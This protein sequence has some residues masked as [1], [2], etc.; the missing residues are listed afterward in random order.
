LSPSNKKQH[1]RDKDTIMMHSGD[2]CS[3]IST[4]INDIEPQDS[5][6][7]AKYS[8]Q[9]Q[10]GG[11]GDCCKKEEDDGYDGSSIDFLKSGKI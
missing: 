3:S 7:T 10:E 5:Q 6:G 9:E 1:Y 2:G 8:E 4:N 11:D